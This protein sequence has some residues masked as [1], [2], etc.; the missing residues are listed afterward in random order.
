MRT[1][2]STEPAPYFRWAP[3]E[4]ILMATY[5]EIPTM[6]GERDMA[7]GQD[8]PQRLQG[9]MGVGELVMSVLAFSAPL[10]TV[11]GFV[12]VL[13]MY[14]G[15]T[16]PAIYIA[17]TVWCGMPL[18]AGH[19]VLLLLLPAARAQGSSVNSAPTPTFPA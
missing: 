7:E 5:E 6:G 9:N 15:N 16:G 4:E 14:S 8:Q 10:T 12:P 1:H 17:A 11:A 2:R 13:L 3:K 18:L 19:A